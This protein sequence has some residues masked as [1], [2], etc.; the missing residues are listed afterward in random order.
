MTYTDILVVELLI[1]SIDQT[2]NMDELSSDNNS[3]LLEIS[4]SPII[5]A[6]SLKGRSINWKKYIRLLHEYDIE[7]N[8]TTETMIDIDVAIE[9]FT[10]YIY[11][12]IEKKKSI[13][14]PV[15]LKCIVQPLKYYKKPKRKPL[16][17]ELENSI[18]THN[19]KV[20]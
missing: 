5:S 12:M 7:I 10:K 16:F 8:P 2:T 9:K 14:K 15:T 13:L 3:I 11:S 19:S 1:G 20:F 17:T 18:V 6:S 4:I